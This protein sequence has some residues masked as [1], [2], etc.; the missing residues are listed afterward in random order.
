[1][2]IDLDQETERVIAEEIEAGR[3]PSAAIRVIESLRTAF[4]NM[5]RT[6]GIGHVRTDLTS[7]GVRFWPVGSYLVIYRATATVQIVAILHGKRNVK[8]ILRDR[9]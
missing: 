5:A 8:R 1:M 6:P 2:S 3:S 9:L 7:S 4:H